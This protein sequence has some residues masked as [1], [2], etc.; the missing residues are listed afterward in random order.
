MNDKSR[1]REHTF[2]GTIHTLND[3]KKKVVMDQLLN[4]RRFQEFIHEWVAA[5]TRF[6]TEQ[7]KVA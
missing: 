6:E 2:R 3:V 1:K 7:R 5:L 4:D